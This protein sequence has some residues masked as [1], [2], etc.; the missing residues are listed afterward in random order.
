MTSTR[1][2]F[3]RERPGA[4]RSRREARGQKP[5]ANWSE[6]TEVEPEGPSFFLSL[7]FLCYFKIAP[8]WERYQ[9]T[10]SYGNM[11]KVFI[12]TEMLGCLNFIFSGISLWNKL[13]PSQIQLS[14]NVRSCLNPTFLLFF[15][16]PYLLQVWVGFLCVFSL[17]VVV[18]LFGWVAVWLGFFWSFKAK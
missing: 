1:V 11:C 16:H 2:W 13:T 14:L 9:K 5:L 4:G 15:P 7:L 8:Q 18:R 17:I 10:A 6:K 12:I 3:I